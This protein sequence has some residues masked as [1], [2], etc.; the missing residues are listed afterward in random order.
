METSSKDILQLLKLFFAL[1]TNIMCFEVMWS[2]IVIYHHTPKL[3]EK[4]EPG[5]IEFV[6]MEVCNQVNEKKIWKMVAAK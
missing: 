5:T 3:T 2:H 1:I 6:E 4:V